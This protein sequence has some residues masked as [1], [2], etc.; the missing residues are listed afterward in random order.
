H[1]SWPRDWSSDVCSSD[2]HLARR[3][4]AQTFNC[5]TVEGHTSTN[6][7]LLVLANGQGSPLNHEELA[8]VDAAAIAVCGDLAR[9]IAADAEGRSEERRVGKV[10]RGWAPR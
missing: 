3:A 6:D 5:V 8:V 1:T 10:G 9:A 4:A 7:T 2:L